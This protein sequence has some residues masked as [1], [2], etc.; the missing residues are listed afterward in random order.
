MSS[1]YLWDLALMT[2]GCRTKSTDGIDKDDYRL[3]TVKLRTLPSLA[4]LIKSLKGLSLPDVEFSNIVEINI[5]P[6]AKIIIQNNMFG[7]AFLPVFFWEFLR[8]SSNSFCFLSCF[9]NM[10]EH[11]FGEIHTLT[12]KEL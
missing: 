9:E 11:Q 6:T 3:P 1:Q 2:E 4:C 10:F 5:Q 7:C 12:K 8:K